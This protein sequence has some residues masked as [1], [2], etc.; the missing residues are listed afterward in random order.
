M[1]RFLSGFLTGTLLLIFAGILVGRVGWL[2]VRA[3]AAMPAW[4]DGWLS[5]SIHRAV[6]RQA[7]SV[8]P[9]AP[10]TE[11]DVIAGG[12]LYL[13]D[14]VGCHGEPGK[15][16]S[17]F[18]ATFYPPAPQLSTAATTY[19]ETQIFWIARHGIRRTGMGARTGPDYT[20]DELRLLAA[21]VSRVHELSP[22]V[23]KAI[24]PAPQPAAQNAEQPK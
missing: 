12:K 14:C 5:A 13:N 3:D 20:G 2:D 15:P 16:P 19:S 11:A 8:A 9:L 18:G 6:A 24:Q 17:D 22:G 4:L 1:K 10:A 21:F 23:L 7:T